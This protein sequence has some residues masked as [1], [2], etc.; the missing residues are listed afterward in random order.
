[1]A[2]WVS[3]V[4]YILQIV[5]GS[6][7]EKILGLIVSKPKHFFKN[8]IASAY[9][10]LTPEEQDRVFLLAVGMESFS[11]LDQ[12]FCQGF[13]ACHDEALSPWWTTWGANQRDVYF[14]IKTDDDSWEYYC[15][16][17]MNTNNAEFDDTIREMLSFTE[18]V[19]VVVVEDDETGN[20][21][22]TLEEP[23]LPDNSNTAIATPEDPLLPMATAPVPI[24]SENAGNY[25]S[26]SANCIS[27]SN[28]L[29]LLV[30]SMTILGWSIL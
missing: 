11:D 19:E 29:S 30:L 4:S 12:N 23:S 7:F 15:R 8:I 25:V 16:Y 13:A 22:A 3:W 27:I 5:D 21:T 28:T 20:V 1:L 17:S 10:G 9:N 2:W 26:S 24:I 14:Y 18:E 6:F